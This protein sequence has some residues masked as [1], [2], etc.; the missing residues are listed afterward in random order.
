MSAH[1]IHHITAIC[2]DAQKCLDFYCEVL[3][4]RLVKRTVNFDDPGTYHFYFG[5]ESGS[6]GTILTFFP[7]SAMA[8]GRQ[9]SGQAVAT[10]FA[11]PPGSLENWQ[12]RLADRSVASEPICDR[13]GERVLVLRDND[14]LVIELIE[15]AWAKDLP[16]WTAAGVTPAMAIRS[17]HGATISVDGY[18]R[19]ARVLLE[20]FGFVSSQ[21][22]NDR[23]RF[24]AGGG[25]VGATI[26]LLCQ[27]DRRHGLMGTGTVHHVAFRAKDEAAQIAVRLQI[28]SAGFNVTPVLDRV[29]FKSIYFREPGGTIFEVATDAPGFA[30]DESSAA[31]GDQLML[32]KW[33]EANRAQIEKI[34]PAITLPG[35][36]AK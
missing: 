11:V 33:L 32:P 15:A 13:F 34:L 4:L 14:G 20:Q 24:V 16:A 9:G 29:Y 36:T 18:E 25:G 8:P 30:L 17:F 1:P 12:K 26:D 23:F 22:A 35:R 28:A 3:G 2:S 21:S 19:T 31:L 6:P 5:D 27:P 7:W 10:A